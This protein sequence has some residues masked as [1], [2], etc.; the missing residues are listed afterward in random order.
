MICFIVRLVPLKIFDSCEC[1]STEFKKVTKSSKSVVITITGIILN[2]TNFQYLI[3][4]LSFL[5]TDKMKSYFAFSNMVSMYNITKK[6]LF[7][8]KG[9][10][11][12]QQ[13]LHVC[14][15]Y[16]EPKDPFS[17]KNLLANGFW[18]SSP[19]NFTCLVKDEVFWL[20]DAFR[21]QM[22]GSSELSFLEALNSQTS[23]H[24]RVSYSFFY[25]N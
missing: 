8:Y 21:K 6:K 25:K 7:V 15:L 22:P 5:I 9:K 19:K 13:Y 1:G 18:P 16:Q 11:E 3:M 17:L 23:F 20:W 24:G 10:F 12:L 14:C 2:G 4:L